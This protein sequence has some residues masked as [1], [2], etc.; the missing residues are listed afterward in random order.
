MLAVVLGQDDLWAKA[1]RVLQVLC[2][3]VCPCVLRVLC[4]CVLRVLQVLCVV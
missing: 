3:C 1:L 4:P 2:P